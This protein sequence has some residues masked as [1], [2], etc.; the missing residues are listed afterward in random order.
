[1]PVGEARFKIGW[2]DRGLGVDTALDVPGTIGGLMLDKPVD[3]KLERLGSGWPGLGGGEGVESFCCG[4]GIGFC[5]AWGLCP[6]TIGVLEFCEVAGGRLEYGVRGL[7]P[8][9]AEEAIGGFFSVGRFYCGQPVAGAVDVWLP[10]SC[11]QVEG[12]RSDGDGCAGDV[13]RTLGRARVK[14]GPMAVWKLVGCNVA[15]VG[16]RSQGWFGTGGVCAH[17][18]G[19]FAHGWVDQVVDSDGAVEVC[20]ALVG[21]GAGGG[22]EFFVNGDA[23]GSSGGKG[24]VTLGLVV[25]GKAGVFPLR[26]DLLDKRDAAL[27]GGFDLDVGGC[28]GKQKTAQG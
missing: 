3:A 20:E 1:V 22:G 7:G 26:V 12:D 13:G 9:E 21:A 24:L 5:G 16:G 10:L 25:A 4:V 11:R 17:Q 27:G 14:N 15:G 8:V 2:A 6:G 23:M 19:A 28:K 18:H